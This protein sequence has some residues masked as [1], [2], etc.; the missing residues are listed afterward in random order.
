ME[1]NNEKYLEEKFIRVFEKLDNIEAHVI[2]T[3]SKVAE[4]RVRL[5]LLEKADLTRLA[6]CPHNETIK[7]L[8]EQTEVSR[9]YT[10]NPKLL[11][12]TVIGAVA[13]VIISFGLVGLS[14]FMA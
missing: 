1:H 10:K 3:N 12:Y 14:L 2:H 6:S 4:N 11:K 5:E 9:F 13:M 8:K 7:T